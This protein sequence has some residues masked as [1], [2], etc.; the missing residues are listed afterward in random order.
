MTQKSGPATDLLSFDVDFEGFSGPLD[1]LCLLVETREIEAAAVPLAEVVHRYAAFLLERRDISI[2]RVAEFLALAAR[3]LLGKI[4]ALFPGYPKA[5]P[6]DSSDLTEGEDLTSLLERYRPYRKAAAYLGHLQTQRERHFLRPP[7]EGP[8][9][10]DLGDLWGLA[11]L[12]WERIA[13]CNRAR[14]KVQESWDEEIDDGIPEA[15]PDEDQVERRME[16]LASRIAVTR[17]GLSLR[18]LIRR[19]KGRMD[20]IVT[21]LALLEMSRLGRVA[22]VQEEVLGDVQ[23]R[24]VGA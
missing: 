12:W 19:E 18:V 14:H 16:E 3:L 1:L 10:Y 4:Q 11:L 23:V 9:Y 13:S 17:G 22:L 8:P 6:E 15:I 24:G 21:L 2:A 20:L 5:D 7:E